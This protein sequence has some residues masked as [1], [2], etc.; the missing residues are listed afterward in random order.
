MTH[1]DGIYLYDE[2]AKRYIDG[3]GGAIDVN[4]GHGQKEILQKITEQMGQVAYVHGTQF[5]TKAVEEYAEALGEILPSG[6]E[7]IYFLSGGAEAVEAA[8]KLARQFYLESGQSQRWRVVARWHSYHGNTLGALSLTGRIGMRRP[9]LPLLID[10]PHF[11]PPYCYRCPFSSTYPKC[12]LEC[13]KALENVIQME[14]PETISGVILEPIIGATVGAVVP[15]DEYFP[16]I[17]EICNRYGILCIDDEIM[18]G[19]GRTGK[20]FAVDHWNAVPDIM[21]L[22]KGMSGGYF[23]LSAVI[24]RNDLVDRLKEKTGGFVHGHT[25]SHHSVACAVGL[26]VLQFIKEN[27]LVDRSRQRGVYLLKRLEELKEF[28]FVGDVRGKG[29]MTAIEF[30]KDQKTKEPFPRSDRFTEKVIDIAFENGLVLYPG[31]GFVD[32]MNGDMVMIGPPFV[33]EE[34]QIDEIMDSLRKTFSK[35]NSKFRGS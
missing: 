31:T 29:L 5:T 34:S 16:V 27:H 32:G 9:Y 6:L 22:G 30:V 35:M 12:E 33:I 3:S 26:A 4:V 17:Q 14:G 21:V 10:F 28:P 23:P 19:M 7:K 11:P 13:A 1:G 20:W 25:F 8:V 15:P 2:N 24:T 18:T